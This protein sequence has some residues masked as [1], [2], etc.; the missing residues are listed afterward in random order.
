MFDPF[1]TTRPGGTAIGLGLSTAHAIVTASGG[2]LSVESEVGEGST[3][4][5]VLPAAGAPAS[6]SAA[7]PGDA[8][9]VLIVDDDPQ[10]GHMLRRLLAREYSVIVATD[11]N[12][13]LAEAA[14][15]HIDVILCDLMMPDLSGMDFF[16]RLSRTAPENAAR[17]IFMTAGAFTDRMRS[18]VEKM[19]ATC[20]RKPFEAETLFGAVRSCLERHA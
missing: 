17:V 11:A 4:R 9:R 13:A 6:E 16:E 20:L 12:A 19:N 14:S 5:V 10:V 2:T 3:F 15:S 1:F 18:F 8:R 7:Q